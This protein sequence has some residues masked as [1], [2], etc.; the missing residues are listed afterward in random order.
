M[1]CN[2][3]RSPLNMASNLEPGGTGAERQTSFDP[4]WHSPYILSILPVDH[5]DAAVDHYRQSSHY[6]RHECFRALSGLDV[7]SSRVQELSTRLAQI[8]ATVAKDNGGARNVRYSRS[9]E[10]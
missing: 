3:E 1:H 8:E 6:W 2:C 5:A 9:R 10:L 4:R 7:M